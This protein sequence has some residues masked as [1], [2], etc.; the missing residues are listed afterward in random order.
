[1][2]T[3]LFLYFGLSTTGQLYVL[4]L[5]DDF[6]SVVWLFS[7]STADSGTAVDAIAQWIGTF[8]CID[9]IVSDQGSQFK[10]KFMEAFRKWFRF[11]HQ[12][13]TAYTSWANGTVE[14]VC[15]EV[16]RACMTL[17]SEWRLSPREWPS[18]T[19]CVLSIL[20][21]VPLKRLGNR[22]GEVKPVLRCPRE[23]FT[24]MRPS[25]PL[26]HALHFTD[27]ESIGSHDEVLARQL[28]KIEELQGAMGYMHKDVAGRVSKRRKNSIK[29]HNKKTNIQSINFSIGDFALV[30]V[31][32]ENGHKFGLHRRGPRR[33]SNVMN[34]LVYEVE[35]LSDGAKEIVHATRILLYR[36]ELDNSEVDPNL[37]AHAEHSDTLYQ[38]VTGFRG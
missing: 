37:I 16:K 3:W 11:S 9:W 28:L 19:E 38:D 6:S 27:H 1:M 15:R 23:V 18:V 21:Q 26:M 13:T 34:D 30:H 14:R 4:I 10:N 35:N 36:A 29:A 22:T 33:I 24:G 31:A 32:G 17:V 25:R 12:F 5:R 8:V 20:N 7:G 2:Y